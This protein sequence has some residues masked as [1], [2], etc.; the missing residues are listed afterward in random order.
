VD[1]T[2]V[3]EVRHGE[4]AQICEIR[5]PRNRTSPRSAVTFFNSPFG[6]WLLSA[7]FLTVGGAALSAR[8]ECLASARSDIES[9]NRVSDELAS[10]RL[11]LM[12]ALSQSSNATDFQKALRSSTYATYKEFDGQGFRALVVQQKRI[13]ARFTLSR[14]TADNFEKLVSS[15]H[16]PRHGR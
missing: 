11:R 13:V 9:Y 4:N 16:P 3:G 5:N 12:F 7:I 1:C 14:Q 15:E 2:L 10:R 6:V 8:Q